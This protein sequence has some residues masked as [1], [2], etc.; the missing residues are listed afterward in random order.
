[1]TWPV[2]VC[3][4]Y[5]SYWVHT[6]NVDEILANKSLVGELRFDIGCP[7][8]I[9]YRLMARV[10]LLMGRIQVTWNNGKKEAENA[11][12]HIK[13]LKYIFSLKSLIKNSRKQ[14][15]YNNGLLIH[16]I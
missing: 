2:L 9:I 1:M 7:L 16:Q 11:F 8:R 10:K 13:I 14:V 12:C 5:S 4:V 3:S 6:F 15:C